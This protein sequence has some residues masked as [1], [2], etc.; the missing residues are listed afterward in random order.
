MFL[1]ERSDLL[2]RISPP[3][4]THAN[5]IPKFR[6]ITDESPRWLLAAGR[7]ERARPVIRRLLQKNGMPH[8]DEV[9]E[10]V[11]SSTVIT[12]KEKAKA[13]IG[14]LLTTKRIAFTTVSFLFQ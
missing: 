11:I 12:V 9:V 7:T 13:S 5:Q 4:L 8:S 6:S 14:D 2:V 3:K 10:E 1:W